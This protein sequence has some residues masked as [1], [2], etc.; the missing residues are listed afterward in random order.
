MAKNRSDARNRIET[1]LVR[2]LLA[3]AGRGTA[4]GAEAAG[5]RLG[6]LYRRLDGRRRRLVARNLERAFPGK[7]PGEIE[8]LSRAVFEHFGGVAA[9]VLRSVREPSGSLLSRIEL[10]GVEGARAAAASGRGVVYLAAH[11]GNWEFSAL[12]AAAAG[13]PAAVVARPLDNPLLEGLLRRYRERTGNTV[14]YKRDAA[15]EIL[16]HLRRGDGVGIL[17]DQHARPPDAV[18]VP[19]FGR[20]ASTSSALARIVDR[21]EALVVPSVCFRTGPARYRLEYG[22]PLDVRTL[23]AGE[24][25][26]ESLTA[27]LNLEV[28]TLVRRHPEQWLWLH[29]RWR[30]D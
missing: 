6:R 5:R 4:E 16:R 2:L 18:V 19:F 29:N 28:E 26:A 30:L 9:D 22:T 21:T 25:E 24:R 17:V 8:A 3:A 1:G 20:P 13:L 14:V 10:S 15:R 23:S 7:T 12:A 11:L 27:R